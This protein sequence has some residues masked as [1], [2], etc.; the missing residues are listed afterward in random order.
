MNAAST[1]ESETFLR[2]LHGRHTDFIELRLKNDGGKWHSE[3]FP[4]GELER[5]AEQAEKLSSRHDVYFGVGARDGKGGARENMTNLPA[6]WV[7]VD[8][9]DGVSRDTLQERV[10]GLPRPSMIVNS[11]GGWHLYWILKEAVGPE[12]FEQI[13]SIN[14]ALAAILGGDQDATDPARILRVPGTLNR[15]K[16]YGTPRP[17]ELLEANVAEYNLSDFDHF[18]PASDPENTPRAMKSS[19]DIQI[20]VE[21]CVFLQRWERDAATLPEPEWYA[22]QSILGRLSGG[23]D[24]IH[25]VS[26][27]YPGYSRKETDAKILHALNDAGPR[28]C[29]AIKALWDCGRDCGVKSPAVLAVKEPMER[30]AEKEP[31]IVVLEEME[32]ESA[33]DL[34]S[35]PSPPVDE[36]VAGLVARREVV[37]CGGAPKGGKSYFTLQGGLAVAGGRDFLGMAVPHPFKVLYVLAEGSKRRF[38]DRLA[39]A[40]PYATGIEDEDLDRLHVVDTRGRLKIDT[41]A[42]EKTLLRLAEPFDLIILDTL[43]ALQGGGDENSHKDFRKVSGP[44]DRLKHSGPDGKAVWLIHHVRKNSAEDAGA[45]ELR[46][47]GFSA[48]SDAIVRLYKRRGK[49]GTHYVVKFDLRNYEEREDLLLTRLG[50]L[51]APIDP[52]NSKIALQNYVVRAVTEAGGRIEGR[53]VLVKVLTEATKLKR[54]TCINAIGEAITDGKIGSA[55]M[56]GTNAKV[57]FL[58]D[59][60]GDEE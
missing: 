4:A 50:P 25:T 20:T 28:T 22:G 11:G 13:R 39:A 21:R 36:V 16:E 14:S 35:T 57:Y 27:R 8:L 41:D 1:R 7:D 49:T 10:K 38:K 17:V 9:K 5:A 26:S 44:L 18:A 30:T 55:S 24:Y 31:E 15:K 59:E 33:R 56:P 42:G 60:N 3:F 58:K 6:V 52:N 43:Y 37:T 19:P 48:F 2:A 46:G 12:D 34:L 53:E 51:F 32:T 54:Q 29:A 47:A 45:D 40:T 23:V